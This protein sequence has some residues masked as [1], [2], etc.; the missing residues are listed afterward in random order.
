[1]LRR[2]FANGHCSLAQF[3]PE[4]LSS[5]HSAHHQT[6]PGLL[7]TEAAHGHL[8]TRY[9]RAFL[10]ESRK[11]LSGITSS[12]NDLGLPAYFFSL[13]WLLEGRDCLTP[14]WATA[15]GPVEWVFGGECCANRRECCHHSSS[16]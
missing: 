14:L 11:G 13:T 6:W 1:M 3:Q 15:P 5:K 9:F 10:R 7:P 8:Q 2:L 16:R 4:R 12:C